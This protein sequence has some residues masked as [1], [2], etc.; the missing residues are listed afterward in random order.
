MNYISKYRRVKPIHRE[1]STYNGKEAWPPLPLAH[2][3]HTQIL[4]WKY[5]D[6]L[7]LNIIPTSYEKR[8][9]T[10]TRNSSLQILHYRRER[11]EA[12]R[13]KSSEQKH[14]FPPRLHERLHL[15]KQRQ[16]SYLYR[17]MTELFIGLQ[18]P[19]LILLSLHR[20]V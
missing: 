13:C 16:M 4:S 10:F 20:T 14:V 3:S 19:S 7:R 8:L 6:R 12:S 2:S 5:N 15:R 17:M 11:S 1:S 9:L 18:I